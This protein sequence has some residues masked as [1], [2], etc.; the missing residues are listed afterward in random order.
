MALLGIGLT[1]VLGVA[2]LRRS[3]SARRETRRD[4]RA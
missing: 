4:I 3:R 2:R 1:T